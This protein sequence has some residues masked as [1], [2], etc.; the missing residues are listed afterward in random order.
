MF[1][2]QDPNGNTGTAIVKFIIE[3][4]QFHPLLKRI[5]CHSMNGSARIA[6]VRALEAE[7]RWEVWNSPFIMWDWRELHNA[8]ENLPEN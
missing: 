4:G 6:M 5:I 2:D 3:R 7:N 8:W 1:V